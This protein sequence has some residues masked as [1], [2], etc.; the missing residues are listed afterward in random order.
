MRP[1]GWKAVCMDNVKLYLGI[2]YGGNA[3]KVGLVDG[4]GQLAGRTSRPTAHL[5]DKVACRAFAAE[6]ADYVHGMGVYS[7]ELKGVGLAIPGIAKGEGFLTPNVRTDWPLLIDSLAR[8]LGKDGIAVIN[9]ANAA[10]LGELWRGAGENLRS[11]LLM[12]IGS[13]IGA[14]LV[15]DGNVVSGGHGAAGEIGHMTV[16]PDGRLCKCGRKGCLERYAS[17]RGLVQTFQEASELPDLDRSR[18]S[19]I[20]PAHE[21]DALAVF[22]AA[23]EDDPRALFAIADGADKLGFALAQAASVIDPA[24]ILIGGGLSK[25][26][27]FYMDSLREAYRR[28]CFAACAATP[29]QCATLMGDAGVI[30]AARYAMLENPRD[31]RQRDWLDPDF[32]L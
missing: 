28:Y 21:T 11:V 7:S 12:T 6:I 3:V 32:G 1:A 5:E 25:G 31:K 30:G 17:A 22:R 29:I 20:E 8:A 14:G 24:I 19:G 10:A 4:F 23:G 2:D 13:G 16:V 26:A 9:D 15:V 18:F 27:D